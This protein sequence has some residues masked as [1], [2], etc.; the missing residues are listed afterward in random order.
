MRSD[1]TV[2]P[3]PTLPVSTPPAAPKK[4]T[5]GHNRYL[6]A[7]AIFKLLQATMLIAT[8]VTALV[9]RKADVAG[10]FSH[11]AAY[12]RIDS[13][14]YI[15][16]DLVAKLHLINAQTMKYLA[17]G[18]FFYGVIYIVEGVGLALKKVWAEYVII[19]ETAL[20]IPWEVYELFKK[21]SPVHIGIF[22]VNI[23]LLVY[24]IV[25]RIQAVWH[26]RHSS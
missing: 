26:K 10:L 13:Q 3:T 16:D 21:P 19:I 18:T 15:F 11:W 8:G 17:L 14:N 1:M 23:L 6:L 25:V 7:I 12:F 20:F 9:F 5:G 22:T 4:E 24:L 2:G